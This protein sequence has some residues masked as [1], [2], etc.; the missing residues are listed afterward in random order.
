MSPLEIILCNACLVRAIRVPY[1]LPVCI[2]SL[3]AYY[4]HRNHNS[5]ANK[6]SSASPTP[7]PAPLQA[8]SSINWN[9]TYTTLIA[10]QLHFFRANPWH[11]FSSLKLLRFSD[12]FCKIMDVYRG[13]I[14]PRQNSPIWWS[15]LPRALEQRVVHLALLPGWIRGCEARL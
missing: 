2:A 11:V 13:R 6:V 3:P 1:C 9:V 4:H 8:P 5:C 12:Q 14:I 15:M 10:P 7:I